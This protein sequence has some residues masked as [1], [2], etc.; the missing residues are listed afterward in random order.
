MQHGRVAEA[1]DRLDTASFAR[2][3]ALKDSERMRRV[4][5]RK[6]RIPRMLGDVDGPSSS[7]DVD[8]NDKTCSPL[9]AI[10]EETMDSCHPS[11]VSDA[12]RRKLCAKPGT[13]NVKRLELAFVC[14]LS[15]LLGCMA[16]GVVDAIR[17]ARAT[18]PSRPAVRQ[19]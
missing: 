8:S 2:D 9:C 10:A 13:V 11:C 7:K 16:P 12:T 17:M 15:F 19:P 4:V 1:R 6:E 14:V 3:R 18:F 5:T